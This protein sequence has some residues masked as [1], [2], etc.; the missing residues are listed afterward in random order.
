MIRRGPS[1]SKA[2][3]HSASLLSRELANRRVR[4]LSRPAP[5][6]YEHPTGPSSINSERDARQSTSRSLPGLGR[7]GDDLG[8]CVSPARSIPCRACCAHTIKALGG[9]QDHDGVVGKLGE[10]QAAEARN[11]RNKL[12]DELF[13]PRRQI[14]PRASPSAFHVSRNGSVISPT[15]LP[16][17]ASLAPCSDQ[18]SGAG[19]LF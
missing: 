16:C 6:K 5:V 1:L 8:V 4:G 7:P 3:R 13:A 12:A 2:E 19:N 18:G 17:S 15:D 14:A 9:G 11:R 10:D